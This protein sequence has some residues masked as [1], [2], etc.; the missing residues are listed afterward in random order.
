M[1]RHLIPK[2]VGAAVLLAAL[3]GGAASAFTASNNVSTSYAGEGIGVVSGYN[4]SNVHYTIAQSNT[5]V[6]GNDANISGVSFH[7]DNHATSAGYALYNNV[8]TAIGGGTCTSTNGYDW[9][10]TASSNPDGYAP[11]VQAS[12]LDVTAVS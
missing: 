12:Y 1:H 7:L 10:C 4:V 6:D 9:T 3:G 2:V 5:P 11:V 8:N